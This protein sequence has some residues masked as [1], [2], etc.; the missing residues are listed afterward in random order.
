MSRSGTGVLRGLPGSYWRMENRT[1]ATPRP[2]ARFARAM[3]CPNH[4]R[5]AASSVIEN[6]TRSKQARSR[7]RVQVV[8]G[9][10]GMC[11]SRESF[12]TKHRAWAT[13]EDGTKNRWTLVAARRLV[14]FVR[15]KGRRNRVQMTLDEWSLVM[16]IVRG[17]V[18]TSSYKIPAGRSTAASPGLTCFKGCRRSKEVLFLASRCW[19]WCQ[20]RSIEQGCKEQQSTYLNQTVPHFP[21][22]KETLF[23]RADQ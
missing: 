4:S 19:G 2:R 6:L 22:L 10:F 8:Q 9:F 15:K 14:W 20:V 7:S 17:P 3:I 18:N 5:A 23:V 12:V 11:L 1:P 13:L 21:H 16:R